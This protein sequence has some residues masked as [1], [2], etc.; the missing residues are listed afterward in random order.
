MISVKR[1]RKVK[2]LKKTREFLKYHKFPTKRRRRRSLLGS[3]GI[4]VD[5][6]SG[7]EKRQIRWLKDTR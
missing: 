5:G 6:A 7:L 2:E 4:Y 1:K 3:E